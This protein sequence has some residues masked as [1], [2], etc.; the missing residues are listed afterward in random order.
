MWRKLHLF[1]GLVAAPLLI[2]LAIT[3]VILSVPPALERWGAV[4][5]ADGEISVAQFAESVVQ[6]Y[7]GAEQIKRTPSGAVIVYYTRD[8]N[9]GADL[10]NPETGE[11]MGPYEPSV[12]SAG[13]RTFI[14][15]SF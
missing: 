7:P 1:P 15:H 10:V 5:P 13:L 11:S 8:G 4:V 9:P 12:F 2:V 3:G 6:Q 14:A